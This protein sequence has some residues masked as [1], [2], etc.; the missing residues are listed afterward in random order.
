MGQ[1]KIYFWKTVDG[2]KVW[3]KNFSHTHTKKKKM[4]YISTNAVRR[5]LN[6]STWLDASKVQTV[7]K[8]VTT[9]RL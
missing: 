4:I 3:L 9:I 5:P 1:I 8:N 7:E 2:K 6:V